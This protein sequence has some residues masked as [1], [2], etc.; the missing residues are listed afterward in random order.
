MESAAHKL[1]IGIQGDLDGVFS[2]VPSVS[3]SLDPLLPALEGYPPQI[4]ERIRIRRPDARETC[5]WLHPGEPV[6][7]ALCAR[8]IDAFTHDARRGAIFIDPRAG[9]PALW[10]L[11]AASIEEDSLGGALIG[12]SPSSSAGEAPR[13]TLESRLLALRQGGADEAPVE[14]PPDALLVLH[15]APGIAPGSVPLASRATALRAGASVHVERHLSLRLEEYRTARSAELPE[16]RRRLNVSFDLRSAELAKRRSELA[17]AATESTDEEIAALKREQAALSGA[18]ERALRN[19]DGAP[20]RIA[21]GPARF[22]A[23]ALALPPPP[24]GDV[25]QLDERVEA[26][27]VRIAA[28]AEAD[29][30]AEVQDISTPEKARAAGLS[31]WPGFDLLSRYPDGKVRSIEVKGR[32]GR[33][34]VR[35]E[36]NEWKQACNLGE[37]YWLYVVFDCATSSPQLYRVQDP[38][39]NLLA[40]EHAATAF[41]ITVGNIVRAADTEM[42]PFRRTL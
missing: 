11:A 19:L 29:R 3:G 1:G 5:I 14:H 17:R 30:G 28:Q 4:R 40:S 38:F 22:L 12:E 36:L 24:D 42:P 15:G 23:H 35:M 21:A 26:M 20:E 7:D 10:H 33:A 18:R 34:A 9:E 37:H 8:V 25:D 31:D 13:C 6:F 16:R 27:A 39:R 41:T 32:A 2:F